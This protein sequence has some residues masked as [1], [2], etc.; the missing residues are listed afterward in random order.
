MNTHLKETAYLLRHPQPIGSAEIDLNLL[1]GDSGKNQKTQ[2]LVADISL[3]VLVKINQARYRSEIERKLRRMFVQRATMPDGTIPSLEIQALGP[4]RRDDSQWIVL[5]FGQSLGSMLK[6]IDYKAERLREFI[7]TIGALK[8]IIVVEIDFPSRNLVAPLQENI[9]GCTSGRDAAPSEVDWAPRLVGLYDLPPS[10]TRGNGIRIGHIDTGFTFHPEL[11]AGNIDQVAATSEID[12]SLGVDPMPGGSSHGT[13][14]GTVLIS[15]A[16]SSAVNDLDQQSDGIT[17]LA[18][19][20][21]VVPVRAFDTVAVIET[22][23][24]IPSFTQ[25]AIATAIHYCVAQGCNVISMS[26]GG[27]VSMSVVDALEDAYHQNVIMCA[28]AGNCVGFVVQPASYDFVIACGGVGIESDGSVRTWPGTSY[29]PKVDISAP[30][31]NVW[32]GDWIDGNAIVRP[33]EGTSYAAPHVAAAA[34]IW[35]EHHGV[36]NLTSYYADSNRQLSDVFRMVVK[37]SALVPANW[38]TSANGAGV[39]NLPQLLSAQL[40]VPHAVLQAELFQLEWLGVSVSVNTGLVAE[41]VWLD[42]WGGIFGEDDEDD[43]LSESDLIELFPDFA[44]PTNVL[45]ELDRITVRDDGELWGG[46]EPYI[47][48]SYLKVDGTTA[49]ITIELDVAAI[50]TGQIDLHATLTPRAG[51]DSIVT[52]EQRGGHNNVDPVNIGPVERRIGGP[53]EIDIDESIGLFETELVPIPIRFIIDGGDAFGGIDVVGLPG[54][55]GVQVLLM[56]EDL[57]PNSAV[58]SAHE[59][60]GEGIANIISDVLAELDLSDLSVDPSSFVEQIRDIEDDAIQAAITEMGLWSLFWS[61]IDADDQLIQ[62]FKMVNA[63]QI[64][65]GIEF[66]GGYPAPGFPKPGPHGDWTLKGE[67]RQN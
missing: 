44:A 2:A 67:I 22:P 62:V 25:T 15:T 51:A 18:Q 40:P 52:V 59:A 8:G 56:E 1:Y 19:G 14:T 35:L 4:A 13:A 28:A 24:F 10:S 46:A 5:D 37:S 63:L 54:F 45:V 36:D 29:G 61:A 41:I 11:N 12:S 3:C 49:E 60:V 66:Q 57:T 27:T 55:V 39:V 38:N 7:K 9:P 30:A 21:T 32:I 17:G 43:D 48:A 26:F 6:E 58:A 16:G 31:D 64:G 50:S 33:G 23:D 65:S 20:A 34:A 47:L 53:I 42:W